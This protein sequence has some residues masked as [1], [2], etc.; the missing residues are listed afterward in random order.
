LSGRANPQR[1]EVEALFALVAAATDANLDD[2]AQAYNRAMGAESATRRV[3]AD[4]QKGRG[5]TFEIS[6]ALLDAGVSESALSPQEREV[7]KRL[8]ELAASETMPAALALVVPA[9]AASADA[10][11]NRVPALRRLS[12]SVRILPKSSLYDDASGRYSVARVL[13]AAGPAAGLTW[14]IFVTDPAEWDVDPSIR[15]LVRL[16]VLL[17]GDLVVDVTARREREIRALNT[18]LIQA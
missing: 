2:L 10:L 8:R 9:N 12:G 13:E 5:F 16:L 3:A 6:A 15:S 18:I 1:A 17:A 14:D 7:L 11:F 4:V